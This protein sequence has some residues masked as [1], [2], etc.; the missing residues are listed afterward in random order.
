MFNRFLVVFTAVIAVSQFGCASEPKPVPL[1]EG[2]QGVHLK[3]YSETKWKVWMD[4]DEEKLQPQVTSELCWA[5]CVRA[6]QLHT[7]GES[8]TQQ[9]LHAKH[10]LALPQS[11]REVGMPE[12]IID[13]MAGGYRDQFKDRFVLDLINPADLTNREIIPSL[14]AGQPVLFAMSESDNSN[15]GHIALI[16]GVQYEEVEVPIEEQLLNAPLELGSDIGSWVSSIGSSDQQKKATGISKSGE[17]IN[18]LADAVDGRDY[19]LTKVYVWDPA[20]DFNGD[21]KIDGGM[22]IY[23]SEHFELVKDFTLSQVSSLELV[24]ERLVW[25]NSRPPGAG[26]YIRDPYD[27]MD[28]PV[29]TSTVDGFD[30]GIVMQ[31][32]QRFGI[33]TDNQREEATKNDKQPGPKQ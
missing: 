24:K 8:L 2:V 17:N 14:S 3:T 11:S 4:L 1:A 29:H 32:N 22:K 12:E 30:A 20:H 7:Q 25:V 26:V 31:L 15:V 13:A 19:K 5:A 21:G 9:E 10:I 23:T 33:T 18:K 28:D 6:I 27:R 16:Y